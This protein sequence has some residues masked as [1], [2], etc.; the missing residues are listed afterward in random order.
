M[1]DMTAQVL[2]VL[3]MDRFGD[4]VGDSVV[5][6][7]REMAFALLAACIK[8]LEGDGP[9]KVLRVLIE[10]IRQ[11]TKQAYVWQVRHAGL[12]GLKYLVAVNER[13]VRTP[14]VFSNIVAAAIIGSV[15]S[16]Y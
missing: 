9:K 16:G 5:A 1:Q 14:D 11:E 13:A 7:V 12:V 6:P 4:Y 3:C 15:L 2:R 8:N 10:M